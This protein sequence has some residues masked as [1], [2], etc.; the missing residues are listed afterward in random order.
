MRR[1]FDSSLSVQFKTENETNDMTQEQVKTKP[2]VGQTLY[3]LNVGNASRGRKS[4]LTPVVVTKVDRKYFTAGKGYRPLRFHLSDWSQKSD[5]TASSR[6]YE[7]EQDYIEEK[8]RSEI[9]TFIGEAFKNGRTSK[10]L[11]L[12]VLRS[13][14]DLINEYEL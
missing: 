9:C 10:D 5:Y 1:R 2:K 12:S 13:I 7:T 14:R 3:S 6:L 4:E 8:E 11:T